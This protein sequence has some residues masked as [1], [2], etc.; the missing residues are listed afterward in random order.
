MYSDSVDIN[1]NLTDNLFALPG[2]A[3]MLPKA[4]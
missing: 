3:K 1:R 2:N 4:R